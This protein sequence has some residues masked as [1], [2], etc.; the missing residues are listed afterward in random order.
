M[1][2]YN[3]G[4]KISLP[5]QKKKPPMRTEPHKGLFRGDA[6]IIICGLLKSNE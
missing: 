6:L 2:V 1:V 5:F 4:S 3:L